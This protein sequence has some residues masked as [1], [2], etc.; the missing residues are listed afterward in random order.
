MVEM[1]K[2][3]NSFTFVWDAEYDFDLIRV[4]VMYGMM[5]CQEV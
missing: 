2:G 3:S 4:A 1:Y 5:D